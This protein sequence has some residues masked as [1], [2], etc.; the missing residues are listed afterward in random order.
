MNCSTSGARRRGLFIA[1]AAVASLSSVAA[2]SHSAPAPH[3][4]SVAVRDLHCPVGACDLL[5]TRDCSDTCDVEQ[6]DYW[7]QD[8]G[9]ADRSKALERGQVTFAKG[10]TTATITLK[11]ILDDGAE[12]QGR[13]ELVLTIDGQVVTEGDVSLSG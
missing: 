7:T 3:D 1:V 13:I 10:S 9:P 4:A 6:L 8:P 12:K 2:C 5:I 11:R